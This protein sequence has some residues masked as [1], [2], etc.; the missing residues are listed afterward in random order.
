ME[1]ITVE[2]TAPISGKL[3]KIKEG[4]GYAERTLLKKGKRLHQVIP[5]YLASLIVEMDG[6]P[7]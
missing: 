5:D 4:D 7:L 6:K 2:V 1:L 3:I